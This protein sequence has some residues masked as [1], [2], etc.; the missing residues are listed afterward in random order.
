[1]KGVSFSDYCANNNFIF[2]DGKVFVFFLQQ[3]QIAETPVSVASQS[4]PAAAAVQI[5]T[6]NNQ[7]EPSREDEIGFPVDKVWTPNVLVNTQLAF[8][9]SRDNASIETA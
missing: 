1:M 8:Q 5:Q 2:V 7:S 3:G 4:V 9:C 6:Q